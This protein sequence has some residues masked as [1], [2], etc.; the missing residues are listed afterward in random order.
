MLLFLK[1]WS[2][3]SADLQSR[4]IPADQCG[5]ILLHSGW[6]VMERRQS[7]CFDISNS[8]G[9]MAEAVPNIL[10]VLTLQLQEAIANHGGWKLLSANVERFL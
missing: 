4:E 8:A 2:R 6:C 1:I 9:S 3:K 7:V 5:I 10:D